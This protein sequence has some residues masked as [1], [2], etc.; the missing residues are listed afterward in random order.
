MKFACS[1]YLCLDF[2]SGDILHKAVDFNYLDE[3]MASYKILAYRAV[4]ISSNFLFKIVHNCLR[5]LH[6]SVLD[7][8][9]TNFGY[10]NGPLSVK[11]CYS[12]LPTG[13]SF[14]ACDIYLI[15]QGVSSGAC[16]DT[17]VQV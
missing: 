2:Q 14:I 17:N 13:P 8:Q 7:H 16:W 6:G 10:H 9:A 4:P 11:H 1:N 3:L 12:G 5:K 15:L